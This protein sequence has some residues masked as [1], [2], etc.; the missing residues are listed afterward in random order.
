MINGIFKEIYIVV[1]CVCVFMYVCVCTCV[2][3]F[4]YVCVFFMYTKFSPLPH[5]ATSNN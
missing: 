3:I 4:M 2:C 5:K 1:V